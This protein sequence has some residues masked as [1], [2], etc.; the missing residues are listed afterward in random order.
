MTTW[1]LDLRDRTGGA[2]VKSDVA[3]RALTVRWVLNGAGSIEVDL[4]HDADLGG[5]TAGTAELQL[6]ADGAIVWAGPWLSSDV[7]PR[8]RSLKLTGEGLWWWFRQ[9][10]VTSDLVYTDVAQETIAWNLLNHTQGQTYGSLAI[11]NGTHTG[12]SKTRRR[13][14]CAAEAPNVGEE[15]E[16]FTEYATGFDFAIDPATRAFDTWTPSRKSSSGI[17]LDGNSVDTLT[18]SEDVRDV[19]NFVTAIGANECGSIV[20]E[21]SD[22]T[23]ANTYGRLEVALDADD[24]DDTRGEVTEFATEQLRALKEPRFDGTITFRE[25]GTGAPALA[26]LIPGNTLTLTDNRG[27]STFTTKTLRM[28]EVAL[29]LDNGL[30][31]EGVYEVSL[32][33]GVD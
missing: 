29:A 1:R 9:R 31:G 26:D 23:L 2:L 30:P 13:V 18:W 17:A 8:A 7:D 20:V 12:T 22:T 11:V 3:F 32:T 19:R 14:Y 16:A 27:Y 6:L 5:A 4:R 33:S 10:I 15:V 24:S 28:V 25:N 21:T